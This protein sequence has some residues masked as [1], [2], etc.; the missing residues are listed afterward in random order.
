VLGWAWAGT[1]RRGPTGIEAV[2]EPDIVLACVGDVPTAETL[3]AAWLLREHVPYL[4]VR[5]VNVVDL[6]ALGRPRCIRTV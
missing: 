3:A 2:A 1:E 6:L 4:R 5:V